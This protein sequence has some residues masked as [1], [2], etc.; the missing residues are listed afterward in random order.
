M[1]CICSVKLIIYHLFAHIFVVSMWTLYPQ[2]LYNWCKD[3]LVAGLKTSIC[4]MHTHLPSLSHLVSIF[5]CRD[6]QLLVK[7]P[8]LSHHLHHL[9]ERGHD[10][11]RPWCSYTSAIDPSS[12][13]SSCTIFFC[14]FSLFLSCLISCCFQFHLRLPCIL[15]CWL[16][17][18]FSWLYYLLRVLCS[19]LHTMP[20]TAP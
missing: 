1:S 8:G 10:T 14:V 20:H 6:S 12:V 3:S 17:L 9:N 16:S 7:S 11:P 19:G 4:M 15:Y 13:A 2:L 5:S 18:V